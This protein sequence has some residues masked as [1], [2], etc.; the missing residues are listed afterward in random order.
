MASCGR[1]IRHVHESTPPISLLS[2]G[3]VKA[4]Y[5]YYYYSMRLPQ[6]QEE[7]TP[8]HYVGRAA[9]LNTK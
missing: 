8:Q 1:T 2:F 6:N 4:T 5:C 9:K 3:V 7:N